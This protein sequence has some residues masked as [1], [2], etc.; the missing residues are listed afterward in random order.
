MCRTDGETSYSST[1]HNPARCHK[2]KEPALTNTLDH[3]TQNDWCSGNSA[4]YTVQT[5]VLCLPREDCE[6][7]CA[8]DERC[9]SFDMH[10]NLP[11]C[12]LNGP[13]CAPGV[14]PYNGPP[15]DMYSQA[16]QPTPLG[17]Y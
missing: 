9:L 12:Y 16:P 1:V 6:K 11:R 10:R 4:D 2:G 3:Q 14:N 8:G 13:Y 17:Q 7:L 15:I 5:D